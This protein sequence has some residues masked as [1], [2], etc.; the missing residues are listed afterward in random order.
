MQSGGAVHGPAGSRTL[1][2]YR[3]RASSSLQ[4]LG[5]PWQQLQARLAGI[6]AQPALCGSIYIASGTVA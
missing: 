4:G 1:A 6:E 2:Q 5:R 3:S